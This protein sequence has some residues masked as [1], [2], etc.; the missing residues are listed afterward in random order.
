MSVRAYRNFTAA[1]ERLG[2]NGRAGMWQ[3][4]AHGDA[5]PSLRV[6]DKDDQVLVHCH[7]GC[8]PLDVLD[9]L[10]LEWR[11]L[12]DDPARGKNWNNRALRSVGAKPAHDGRVEL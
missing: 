2:M 9:R 6:T 11:D 4:P 5:K 3:C 8:E 12:F 7:A 10:G 1:L